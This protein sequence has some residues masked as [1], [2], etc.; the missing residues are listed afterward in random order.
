VVAV[1]RDVTELKNQEQ[2]LEHA[3]A[4]SDLANE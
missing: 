2:E 1:M 3:R 4:E